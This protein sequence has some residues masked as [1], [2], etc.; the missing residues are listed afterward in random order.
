[1]KW[2]LDAGHL[3]AGDKSVGTF[4]VKACSEVNGNSNEPSR[5]RI[6][7][8]KVRAP[9]GA[10]FTQLFLRI[11]DLSAGVEFE[12]AVALQPKSVSTLRQCI[13]ANSGKRLISA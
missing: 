1:M 6:S 13:K 5:L 2:E 12:P 8:S 10:P 9:P 4:R 11:K 3:T 7:R